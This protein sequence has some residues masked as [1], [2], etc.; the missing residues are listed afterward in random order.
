ML[1][2][3][4]VP[5][6]DVA[7]PPAPADGEL[8]LGDVLEEEAQ[9]RVALLRREVEDASREARVDVDAL[10]AGDGVG[11]DD[12]V[13]DGRVLEPGLLPLGLLLALP[14]ALLREGLSAASRELLCEG[15]ENRAA[16]VVAQ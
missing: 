4:V 7:G 2:Q 13:D 1:G 3:A 15:R 9:D 16:V 11:A 8:G 12:R 5:E 6:R 14:V 10:P